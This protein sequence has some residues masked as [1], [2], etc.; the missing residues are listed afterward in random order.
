MLRYHTMTITQAREYLRV[1]KDRSGRGRSVEEQHRDH[2]A[3]AER[4]SW[5]LGTAYRDVD[6]SASRYARKVRDGF[7]E[8]IDD[9]TN[10]TFG[11]D[12]LMIWEA[13]RGSRR[14]GEWVLLVELCEERGVRI[15][16]HT[17][18]TLY[19][20]ANPRHRRNLLDDAVD[21]EYESAKT[22]ERVLRST[23]ATAAAGRPH[24]KLLYG[25]AREYDERGRY[26]RQYPHPEQAP[27]VREMAERVDAGES[28]WTIAEDL[29]RR[30]VP[31]PRP[32][33]GGQGPLAGKWRLEQVKRCVVNPGIAGF[34][35]HNGQIVGKA[36]WPTI[37]DEELW[38]RCV[39]RLSDPRRK[40]VRDGAVKHLLTG[41]ARCGVC[42][43]PMRTLKQRGGYR[44]YLCHPA[45]HVAIKQ[46]WLD[47]YITE[48]VLTRMEQPDALALLVPPDDGQAAQAASR[49][50]EELEGYLRDFYDR[51]GLGPGKGVSPAGLAAIEA[52]VLPRIEEL[53]RQAE[54]TSV[55]EAIRKLAGPRAREVWADPAFTIALKRE[56]VAL[57]LDIRVVPAAVRGRKRFDPERVKWEWR[58]SQ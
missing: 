25:Y 34:R 1:S 58:R 17:H 11:A 46:D 5:T 57:V 50:I 53:R 36:D 29:N 49:E 43:T 24:G 33:R 9:L 42:G 21:S 40:T 47:E 7:A 48:L 31:P 19:D 28:C 26:V 38:S 44:T 39:A 56:T 30:G 20:P 14:V 41:V 8:L 37:I 16:V 45:S 18:S 3:D 55:P 2:E 35:V 54:P 32:P 4:Q 10:G 15:W 23:R 12:I 52:K 22:R 27:I 6:V 13:S 51:A